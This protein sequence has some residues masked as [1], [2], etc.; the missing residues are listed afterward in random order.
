MELSS[1]AR[2]HS[3]GRYH[4][5]VWAFTMMLLLT[6]L[7]TIGG[8]S[9]KDGATGAKGDQG[10]IGVTGPTGTTGAAGPTGPVGPAGPTG[11]S[12]LSFYVIVPDQ[13][14]GIQDA[15]DSLPSAGG[16]VF[17]RSGTYVLSQGIHI[18]R[19]NITLS[20]ERGTLIQ[21]GNGVNQPVV[22]IGSDAETPAVSIDNIEVADLEIDGNKDFQTSETD[23]Q[24]SWIRNNGIDVRMVNDLWV[25]GVVVRGA[26]SGGVVVSWNSS[27]ISISDSSF[28]DNYFDGIALYTSRDIHV[29]TFM[30]YSNSAAGLSLDNQLNNVIFS[31]G[32]VRNNGDVGIFVRDS[33]DLMFSNLEIAGNNADGCFMSHQTDGSGNPISGTGVN[34]L[35]FS[36][37]SFLDNNRNGI[38]L[39]SPTSLSS[40][41]AVSGSLFSGNTDTAIKVDVGG[42]LDQSGNIIQ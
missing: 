15:I 8:C 35:F 4:R 21:L 31:D 32:Q 37:C 18:N 2:S 1:F 24:R 5:A 14:S 27:R 40:G 13:F 19:S 29:S 7:F 17:V 42:S 6:A 26:R 28:T 39:A 23:P 22:L 33:S 12:G 38:W 36:G 34:R 41:N 9:G 16:S 10:D 30:T 20:G 3:K 25:S 11:P